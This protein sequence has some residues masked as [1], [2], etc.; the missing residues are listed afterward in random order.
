METSYNP[1]NTFNDLS[2]HSQS[3]NDHKYDDIDLS[4]GIELQEATNNIRESSRIDMKS[5]ETRDMEASLLNRATQSA[6][7]ANLTSTLLGSGILG[8]LH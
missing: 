2:S 6:M 3:S 8:K 4:N 7:Y 1:V 5:L